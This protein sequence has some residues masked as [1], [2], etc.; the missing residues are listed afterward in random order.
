MYISM[1]KLTEIFENGYFS[2]SLIYI[3][4][5]SF[6]VSMFLFSPVELK[7]SSIEYYR[8]ICFIV[9]AGAASVGVMFGCVGFYVDERPEVKF[10]VKIFYFAAAGG[11]V[12]YISEHYFNYYYV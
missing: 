12:G 5:G 10:R 9:G 8:I 7:F 2:L 11:A 1:R 6:L 3:V 4:I